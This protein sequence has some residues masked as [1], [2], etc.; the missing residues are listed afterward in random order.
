MPKFREAI[1]LPAQTSTERGKQAVRNHSYFDFEILGMSKLG[2][3]NWGSRAEIWD[4]FFP[5]EVLTSRLLNE[6]LL[7]AEEIDVLKRAVD[8][9]AQLA[10]KGMRTFLAAE[11][12]WLWCL[13]IVHI[14][15]KNP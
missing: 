5:C 1:L 2:I 4:R 3:R 9:S 14:L 8:L 7:T 11:L 13:E 15:F 6:K 12:P 10:Q